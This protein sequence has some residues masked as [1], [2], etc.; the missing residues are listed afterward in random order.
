MSARATYRLTKSN[1]GVVALVAVDESRSLVIEAMETVWLLV[2]KVA[3]IVS[4]GL[5]WERSQL[6]SI[7]ERIAIRRLMA[8]LSRSHRG[9]QHGR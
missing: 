1:L 4:T 8:G 3:G 2:H 6:T 9:R 5:V 7:E